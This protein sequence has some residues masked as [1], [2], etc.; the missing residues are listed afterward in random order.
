M[1]TL[2]NKH[3]E[4]RLNL[5]AA[6]ETTPSRPSS[7]TLLS[8]STLDPLSLVPRLP[9]SALPVLRFMTNNNMQPHHFPDISEPGRE[10]QTPGPAGCG[11]PPPI[12]QP[13]KND[14]GPRSPRDDL[15]SS[16][17]FSITLAH[18]SAA[19]F[20]SASE[21]LFPSPLHPILSIPFPRPRRGEWD[22]PSLDPFPHR[23]LYLPLGEDKDARGRR[24]RGDRWWCRQRLG[25]ARTWEG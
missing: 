2:D 9:L 25:D 21:V 7:T 4:E 10:L 19:I 14:G 1:F 5:P 13:L 22:P 18:H 16:F 24:L 15:L 11:C 8:Y 6:S 3:A 17:P 23:R 20:L 12:P